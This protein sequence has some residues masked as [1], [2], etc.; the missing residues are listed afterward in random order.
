MKT[1]FE[2]IPIKSHGL[3]NQYLVDY[4]VKFKIS[5]KRYSK[6]GDYR[7]YSNGD[8]QISVNSNLNPY[9]FLITLIHEISHLVAFKNYGRNINPHGKEWKETFK[10]LMNPFLKV[11]IFPENLL[12]T[13]KKH[14]VNPKSSTDSDFELSLALNRYNKKQGLY[15]Y[16]IS[17]GKIFKI[18]NGK[19][20][21]KVLVRRKKIECVELN[22][23]KRYLFSPLAEVELLEN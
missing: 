1:I 13:L 17:L 11:D 23:K 14:F 12:K 5:N 20:F 18:Y 9:R 10:S 3:V 22:S 4:P 19:V 2:Y 6:H 16:E 15:L 8:E 21:R 7:Y